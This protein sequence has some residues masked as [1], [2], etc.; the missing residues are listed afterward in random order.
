MRHPRYRDYFVLGIE[1]TEN[2]KKL[3][4]LTNEEKPYLRKFVVEKSRID[5]LRVAIRDASKLNVLLKNAYDGRQ[6][7]YEEYH[8]LMDHLDKFQDD[9]HKFLKSLDMQIE[10]MQL[11]VRS[12]NILKRGG[13]NTLSQLVEMR[14]TELLKLRH[15]GRKS[16]EEIN[17]AVI[18]LGYEIKA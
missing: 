12:Y 4:A 11:S 9:E 15:M 2:K 1:E 3:K 18:Q 17:E 14:G 8:S 6:L 7:S 13:I 5:A 10:D 16:C